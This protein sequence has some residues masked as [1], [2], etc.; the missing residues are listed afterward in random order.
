MTIEKYSTK[1]A[2]FVGPVRCEHLLELL[3][4]DLF[5]I[6]FILN[7]AHI[8]AHFYMHSAMHWP[9]WLSLKAFECQMEC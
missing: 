8:F 2:F 1:D 7:I 9:K 6:I 3:L 4:I 5:V